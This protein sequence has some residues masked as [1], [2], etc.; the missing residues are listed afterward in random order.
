M[1]P[2]SAH[3][4]RTRKQLLDIFLNHRTVGSFPGDWESVFRGTGYEFWGLREMERGDP[5]KQIDWKTRARTGRYFVRE[6][7]AESRTHFM[8]LYDLSRSM[9]FGYKDLLQANIAVSMAYSAVMANNACGV[10]F[11]ADDVVD[12]IPPKMGWEHF[13]R[14]LM[15]IA[16]REPVVCRKT[17]IR[18]ALGRLVHDLPES[19]TII[20][21][22]FLYPFDVPHRFG[23]SP[24]TARPH[25]VKA[26]QILADHEVLPPREAAGLLSLRDE[27][28]GAE[29]V[30]DLA[31]WKA[32]GA[33]IESR[34]EN[35]RQRLREAGIDVLT[36]T[37]SD[38]YPRKI[39]AFMAPH[40]RARGAFL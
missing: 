5:Y 32:T 34:M 36:L 16:Q 31:R 18:P 17:D 33:D 30:V 9:A 26:F 38:D 20:L 12:E 24:G 37:P 13:E 6:H 39:N 14:L 28:T 23:G 19:L 3:T 27:E 21:S 10:I 29:A 15:A 22:D 25:E 1:N 2:K 7:L 35:Q 11:F 40:P 4:L 8:I